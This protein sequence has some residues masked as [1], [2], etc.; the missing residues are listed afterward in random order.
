MKCVSCTDSKVTAKCELCEEDLCKKCV[1]FLDPETF[2]Y[3]EKLPVELT[4]TRYC[5][6]CYDDKIVLAQEKYSE[7]LEKA[8]QVFVFF[9]TQKRKPNLLKRA[10]KMVEI[11]NCPDRDMTILKLAFLAADQGFNA[12]VDTLVSS[13]K[14][15]NE[16][17]QKSQWQGK[18]LPA[19]VD[20]DKLDREDF[21]EN[22]F[23]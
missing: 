7:T 19:T 17:Y 1:Q 15:R 16:G 18:G 14:V 8:K 11:L 22:F 6:F 9:T 4:H 10:K 20:S 23:G 12:L 21:R 5:R 2:Q 13:E 3:Q